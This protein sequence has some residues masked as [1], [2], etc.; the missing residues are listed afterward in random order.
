MIEPGGGPAPVTYSYAVTNTGDVPLNRPGA[1][2]PG[3]PG[4]TDPGWIVDDTCSPVTYVSGDDGNDLL[5]PEETWLFTCAG[6]VDEPTLN[7]AEITGQP[8][9]PDG[10][11]LPVP[12]VEGEDTAFVDVV[13]PGI[14]VVKTALVPVVLDPGATPVLGPDVPIPPGPRP[15]EYLYEVT[16]T[17]TVPLDL[18]PDPPTDN[19]CSPLVFVPT[20]DANGNGLLDPEETWLYTCATK[21]DREGDANTPPNPGEL[22]G[23]VTNTVTAIGVPVLDG[24]SYPDRSVTG[25][26]IAQVLVIEPSITLTKTASA[27]IVLVDSDVTYTY[28][29][30]NTG[31]VGL[32]V[33]GPADDKCAPLVFVSGDTN[34]ND[35]L[36]GADSGQRE[37]W[38]YQCTR[39]L[40]LPEPPETTDVNIA[41]VGAVDPLGNFYEATATAEVRVFD[42]AI[43]L[44]KSVNESLVPAGTEVTYSFDVTNVG[45]S[46]VTSDDVLADILLV[47]ASLPPT[48]SCTQ[49]TFTG[50]DTNGDGLLERTDPPE[51]WTYE[52]SAVVTEPTTDVA[53]VRGTG[54]TQFDPPLPINVFDADAAFVQTFTPGIAVTKTASPTEIGPGGQVTYTYEVRNTGDVPLSGVADRITDDKCSPVTYVSGDVDGDGL[55]DT[56]TSIF[57]DALDEVWTFTCTTTITETTTNTVVVTGTPTDPDGEPLCGGGPQGFLAVQQIPP[58]DATGQGTATV[59]LGGAI[60]ITKRTPTATTTEFDFTIGDRLFTLS[61][62]ASQTFP[63]LAAGTYVVTERE[64]VGWRLQRI[65]CVDA[66]GDTVVGLGARRVQIVLSAGETVSCTFHNDPIKDLP[67]TGSEVAARLLGGALLL[68]LGTV[69]VVLARRRRAATSSG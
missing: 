16:N 66:S 12:P 69:L 55:L 58:C 22:S 68:G 17:G 7:I 30:A 50:G 62:D 5:D 14:A 44:V 54:G 10:S 33:I 34:G 18:V 23:L 1:F 63:G 32:E 57:E 19:I 8:S 2:E 67:K 64:T 42:P 37:S 41:A 3:E 9:A 6:S 28:V 39:A 60:T 13:T 29:V 45:E 36:D 27:E 24:I 35:I 56:P 46:P 25:T 26:D 65:E 53:V 49:P 11:P 31:D 47:D 59:T 61:R 51:V 20:S 40:G 15:A 4:P 52:C 38:T 48:P 43:S 21:L